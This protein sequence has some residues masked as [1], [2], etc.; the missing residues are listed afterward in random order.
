[1]RSEADLTQCAPLS[2]LLFLQLSEEAPVSALRNELLGT[3]LDH[4][5]LVETQ[6]LPAHR[7]LGVVLPLLAV[8]D[9]FHRLESIVV[10]LRITFIHDEP[11]TSLRLKSA[12]VDRLG[13]RSEHPLRGQR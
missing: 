11:G 1:V 2:L 9:V 7:I 6:R 10:A 3:A 5:D 8:G 12:D 4:A 13:Q